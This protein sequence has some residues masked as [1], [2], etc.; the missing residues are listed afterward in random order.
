MRG[1]QERQVFL[2]RLSDALR[3]L[4]DP[5][6]VQRCAV[7]LLG[8]HLGVNRVGYFE[9]GPDED[10][11]FPTGTCEH[12]LPPLPD[13]MLISD[14]GSDIRDRFR[15]NSAMVS[16]DTAQDA[17]S[18]SHKAAVRATEV[19]A[20][21]GVPL[22]KDG[23]WIATVGV[24]SATPRV[25]KPSEIQLVEEVA[26]RTWAAVQR[27]RDEAALRESE[28]RF[29]SVAE[30]IEDVFY[31]VDLENNTLVYLSPRYEDIWGWPAVTI[32]DDLGT[33]GDTIHPDDRAIAAEAK[34]GQWRGE[35]VTVE[36]RVLRSDGSF[37]W[38]LDRSFAI[39]GAVR[40]R[41]AG[42]ASD[43]TDRRNAEDRVRAGDLRLRLLME[44]IRDYAIFTI[45]LEGNVTSWL[46]G[47]E[48][49]FGWS[50]AEM[51]GRPHE[52]TYLPDDVAQQVPRTEMATAMRDGLALN[53]RWHQRSDQSRVFINGSM[54]PLVGPD[55]KVQGFI[56][57]GRD[58][59][60]RRRVQQALAESEIRLRPLAEGIP[61]LVWRSGDDGHWTWSSLQWQAFTGQTLEQS[62]GR[63]WLEAVHC[64]DREAAKAAWAAALKSGMLDIE[65]RVRRASD[66]AW[67]WH[68]PARFPCE[69]ILARLSSGSAPLRMC[70]S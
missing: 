17:G 35:P 20:W 8:E 51:L 42:V 26:E 48:V 24:H 56:K 62:L 53:V 27:A 23:R 22:V 28:E 49:A 4:S 47:A 46:A 50:E 60:E 43:I 21:I 25:W 58:E 3:P 65:Y 33:F 19:R 2:L 52:T 31:L 9:I 38:I 64:D 39:P 41:L 7:V 67:L 16:A 10:L 34:V 55:G 32:L 36:Y 63:G 68:H 69:T 15:E 11:I 54:Q 66:G 37:R 13:R 45:D 6:Q 44:N 29:R 14:F 40:R 57:I 30:A 1:S 61:Q 12:G 59:T 70:R 5:L 18:E